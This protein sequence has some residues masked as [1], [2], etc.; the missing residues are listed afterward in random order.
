MIMKTKKP[1]SYAQSYSYFFEDGD[2]K[3]ELWCSLS[4]LEKVYSNSK[5]VSKLRNF[6]KNS[7]LSFKIGENEYCI[8]LQIESI[9]LGPCF[10]TLYKN[11]KAYKKQKL[12]YVKM[13]D[14][15]NLK[16]ISLT[17][18]M[19]IVLSILHAFVG[20]P[21]IVAIIIIFL[22]PLLLFNKRVVP[23]AWIEDEEIV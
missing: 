13:R 3:I 21:H 8:N 9:F 20:M 12:T 19:V 15:L 6:S 14:L 11:N 22:S 16:L 23:A 1:I 7:S 2:N 5:L 17:I 10:C 4:G 18:T